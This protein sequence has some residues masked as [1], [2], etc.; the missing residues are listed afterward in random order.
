MSV[1][2]VCD[3]CG[4]REPGYYNGRYWCKPLKWYSKNINNGD[5]AVHACDRQ[6]VDKV[7]AREK[8]AHP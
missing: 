4:K 2:F 7:N 8:K 3:G 6:C 1:I 5:S